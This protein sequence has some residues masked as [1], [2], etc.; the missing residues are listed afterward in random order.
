M[1]GRGLLPFL[2]HCYLRPSL[3]RI[4]LLTVVLALLISTAVRVAAA[5]TAIAAAVV[6]TAVLHQDLPFLK[7]LRSCLF[8]L[9]GF[10]F[11]LRPFFLGHRHFSTLFRSR[12]FVAA[13]H[14][15]SRFVAFPRG[16]CLSVLVSLCKLFEDRFSWFLCCFEGPTC[17]SSSSSWS[18]LPSAPSGAARF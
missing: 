7:T 13:Y 18:S 15:L 8:C 2:R 17:R 16:F 14:Y 10:L 9:H 12:L 6:V 11:L 4:I 5:A 3:P 1:I